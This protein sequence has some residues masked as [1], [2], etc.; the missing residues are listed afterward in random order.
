MN[1]LDVI[2]VLLVLSSLFRGYEIGLIRQLFSTA[3]FLLG[4][5]IGAGLQTY[6]V[7]LAHTPLSRSIIT[8]ATTIGS[9]FI[10]LSLGEQIGLRL[11]AR[12]HQLLHINKFDGWLGSV[13]GAATLVIT[14][15]L[16]SGILLSLPSPAAQKQIRG[17]AIISYL[18]RSLPPAPKIVASFGKLIDPNGF[19]EVFTGH[20]PE[21]LGNTTVPGTS[22]MLQQAVDIA[23]LSTVKIE[24]LGCGGIVD[25]SG[26]VVGADLV[27]TNAHVIAGV[28]KPYVKD[29]TGQHSAV[30]IWFDPNLDFALVRTQNLAGPPLLVSKV[31]VPNGTQGAVLGYPGGGALS[32]GGAKVLDNFIARGRDIYGNGVTN[33]DVY[34]LAADVIP[35]NSGGPVITADGQVIGVI[36]AQSTSYQSVGYALTAPQI[37]TAISQAQA[38]NRTIATGNCAK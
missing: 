34:S 27:A 21:Q 17:S 24:G 29:S 15:W 3:G 25:G 4:L 38:Q 11:K 36:F 5:L 37:N 8:I 33:R 14:I 7:T 23:K 30:A 1:A 22:A 18:N 32:A 31:I 16:A 13:V 9:A 10:V 26:F 12:V 20:E 35:G 28:R 2:I 6:T 19:P